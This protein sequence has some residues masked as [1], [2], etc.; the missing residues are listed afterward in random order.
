M[1]DLIHFVQ[2]NILRGNAVVVSGNAEENKIPL[3]SSRAPYL[4]NQS[5]NKNNFYFILFFAV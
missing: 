2:N 3:L 1:S 4:I 5:Q